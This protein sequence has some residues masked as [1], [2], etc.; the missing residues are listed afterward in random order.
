MHWRRKAAEKDWVLSSY[1]GHMSIFKELVI[2][3]AAGE[4]F[5]N[6]ASICGVTDGKGVDYLTRMPTCIKTSTGGCSILRTPRESLS[7]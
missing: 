3:P 2:R 7:T 1:C 4:D 5:E 6:I